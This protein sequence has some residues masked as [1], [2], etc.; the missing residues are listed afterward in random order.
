MKKIY[1]TFGLAALF[2]GANAQQKTIKLQPRATGSI[3]IAN[4]NVGVNAVSTSTVIQI[5]TQTTTS[6]TVEGVQTSTACTGGGYL[7]GTNCYGDLAKSNFFPPATFASVTSSSITN[8]SFALFKAGTMGTNGTVKT[9]TCSIY[10]G[11]MASGPTGA[12][13]AMATASLSQIVA[14]QTGTNSLFLYT[15]TLTPVATPAAGFFASLSIPNTAGDTIAIVNQASAPA[16]YGW[17]KQSDNV[18]YDMSSA[19]A[20]TSAYK[21]SFSIYPTLMGTVATATAT[22]IKTNSNELSLVSA[23]PN[24]ATDEVSI[25]FGLNQASS[26]EIEVYDVTGKLAQAIKLENLQV[27][28]HTS[29]LNV[30]DLKAGVYMYSVK[31]TNAKMFSKFVISK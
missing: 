18:W 21:G 19:A 14:A 13:I 6:L 5:T 12:A 11:T 7:V 15:F 25:N 16:N 31:S 23:F 28:E 20:W 9:V 26:V 3:A 17:E 30:S 2:L 10:N 22:G 24:P 4:P 8:V 1:L 27:G 29:K